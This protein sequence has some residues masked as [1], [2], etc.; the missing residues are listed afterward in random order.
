MFICYN[1]LKNEMWGVIL[2]DL[3]WTQA[4]SS[5]SKNFKVTIL[6]NNQVSSSYVR[7]ELCYNCGNELLASETRNLLLVYS[8]STCNETQQNVGCGQDDTHKSVIEALSFF[9]CIVLL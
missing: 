3:L 2:Q 8:K 5:Q 9:M 4:D 6:K 1:T 7:D